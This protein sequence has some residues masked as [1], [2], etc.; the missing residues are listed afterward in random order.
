MLRPRTQLPPREDSVPPLGD[1][2]SGLDPHSTD[3]RDA[4][5]EAKILA[6]ER[7]IVMLLDY[8]VGEG[9]ALRREID[10]L[11]QGLSEL[12]TKFHERFEVAG[13]NDLVALRRDFA[14]LQAQVIHN[15]N[16]A[17]GNMT[18]IESESDRA[19]EAL[20]QI[21]DDMGGNGH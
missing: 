19:K 1:G 13:E 6:Q 21:F 5:L 15:G 12:D 14:A 4:I 2:H 16:L 17:N 20:R 11:R 10:Q 8:Q 7:Q 3:E 9:S 18:E